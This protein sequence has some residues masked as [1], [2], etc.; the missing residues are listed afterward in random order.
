[1]YIVFVN[2]VMLTQGSRGGYCQ[3]DLA[4]LIT[5]PIVWA[6]WAWLFSPRV[7]EPQGLHQALKSEAHLCCSRSIIS[8][9]WIFWAMLNSHIPVI[10]MGNHICCLWVGISSIFSLEKVD[11]GYIFSFYQVKWEKKSCL[12]LIQWR[13]HLH[14]KTIIII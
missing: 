6:L 3:A 9:V 12:F 7:T 11:W 4:Q 13:S 1:M 14:Y 10:P 2:F 8:E 5:L